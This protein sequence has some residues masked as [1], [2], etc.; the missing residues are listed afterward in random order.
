MSFLLLLKEKERKKEI[1]GKK[2]ARKK[3]GG[4][5]NMKI[6]GDFNKSFV[7]QELSRVIQHL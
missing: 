1:G 2:D 4:Y 5:T 6:N 3:E 7:P